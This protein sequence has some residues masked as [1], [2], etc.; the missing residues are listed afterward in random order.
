MGKKY[1]LQDEI[2]RKYQ[3]IAF[4]YNSLN[5]IFSV[6]L[7]VENKRSLAIKSLG[8]NLGDTVVDLCCGT[9]VNFRKLKRELGANGSIIGVDLTPAM[10][11]QAKKRILN[12]NI[13]NV[14]LVNLPAQDYLLAEE[15][16]AV[17]ITFAI[18]VIP[19]YDQIIKSIAENIRPGKRLVI[20]ELK[21]S[22]K[23]PRLIL[24]LFHVFLK[25]LGFKKE[26]LSYTPWNS[27][28]KYF[29]NV[30]ITEFLFGAM[31]IAVAYQ[32]ENGERRKRMCIP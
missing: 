5:S 24:K 27:M 7:R 16:D 30:S 20:L 8:L 11:V 13:Q 26:Q 23:I 22:N 32:S 14:Q 1:V 6:I 21:R 31:Y 19:E 28:E 17:L 9:G 4:L 15:A 18:T 12:D 10:L 2:K 25:P 3:K 29:D